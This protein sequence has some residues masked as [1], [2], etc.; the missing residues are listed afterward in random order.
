MRV[1]TLVLSAAAVLA[2]GAIIGAGSLAVSHSMGLEG[3]AAMHVQHRAVPSPDTTATGPKPAPVVPLNSR[4][5]YIALGDSFAAGMGSGDEKGKCLRS[6]DRSYPAVFADLAS[7]DMLANSACSGATTE[8]VVK[9]QLG[10]LDDDTD[11]VTISIGGN[12]LGVAPLSDACG[13]GASTVCKTYFNR[14]LEALKT[15]PDQLAS[16]YQDVADAAPNAEIVVTGYA[17]LFDI[18]DPSSPEFSTIAAVNTATAALNGVIKA[19][20]AKQQSAGV[21]ISYVDV[22]FANHGIG[23][24]HPWVNAAGLAAFHPTAAGYRQYAKTV[25]D[26]LHK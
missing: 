7:I 5:Q 3:P 25:Y 10:K 4:T 2:L 11:L 18:P 16:T 24:K 15:L 22:N 1:R 21:K 13:R 17:F 20:V 8:D 26:A 14:A 12:D 9:K 19:A 23:S 6:K